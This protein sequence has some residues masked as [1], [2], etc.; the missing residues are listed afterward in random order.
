MPLDRRIW[1]AVLGV[2]C[3]TAVIL[4]GAR[5]WKH[6]GATPVVR[7]PR[8]GG[9]AAGA[10]PSV[11]IGH[12]PRIGQ[13]ELGAFAP[14]VSSV[15]GL[16][17]LSLTHLNDDAVYPQYRDSV[18]AVYGADLADMNYLAVGEPGWEPR[19]AAFR[20]WLFR[21]AKYGDPT[22]AI[23]PLGKSAYGAFADTEEMQ[24]LRSVFEEANRAGITVWV[25]FASESN[26]R[27]SV[28]SVYNNPEKIDE[29]R[30]SVRWFR[31]YMPRNVRL[32]FSPLINTAYLQAPPQ[33]FTLRRM[34]ARG[35]Y[36]RIGGTL[37]A[38]TK[39]RLKPAYEWYHA[40][41]RQLDPDCPFQIC[42]L[43]GIFARRSDIVEFL[44]S[45]ANNAW[46]DVQ[47]VNLFAGDLNATAIKDHGHFGFLEPGVSV[48]YIAEFFGAPDEGTHGTFIQEEPAQWRSDDFTIEGSVVRTD[49][50]TGTVVV[51]VA[52][53]TDGL[54]ERAQLS[55]ARQKT[56]LVGPETSLDFPDGRSDIGAL[57]PGDAIDATGW[58]N[59]AGTPL[60]ASR[61]GSDNL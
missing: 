60:H 48:S 45:L 23:E 4:G 51:K 11:T 57:Q 14:E 20:N 39:L 16:D 52:G 19:F 47:R 53:I 22:I 33:L 1:I 21:A 55:H 35:D 6:S 49:T 34:Y 12:A 17:N 24:R 37:Y 27:F 58:D 44:N 9:A 10:I 29:Y 25:R 7:G 8:A 2:T 26:L 32:V 5:A 3:L 31:A 30:K 36:D 56:V 61:I 28:Y 15:S 42:E 54:G 50:A 59:G 43:G 46:P 18:R 40:F 41:M 13:V 38:T